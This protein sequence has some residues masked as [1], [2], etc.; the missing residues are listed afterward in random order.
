M[1]DSLFDEVSGLKACNFIKRDSN[2][3]VACEIS[4]IFKCTYFQEGL[5]MTSSE[6]T[7]IF[8]A[9]FNRISFIEPLTA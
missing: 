5:P 7:K 8:R 2:T 6:L 1:L 9:I 4:E 3:G